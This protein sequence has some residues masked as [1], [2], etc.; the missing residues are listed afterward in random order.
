MR[1][2]CITA[3]LGSTLMLTGCPEPEPTPPPDEA[4]LAGDWTG[5]ASDGRV[6]TLT[7]DDVG[8][9]VEIETTGDGGATITVNVPD[10]TS[11]V[12]GDNVRVEVPVDNATA[13]YTGTLSDNQNRIDG[14]LSREVSVTDNVTVTIPQGPLDLIRVGADA[15]ED[16]TCDEGEECVDG[17]CVA[18]DSCEGVTCD[19]GEECVNGQCVAVDPC[20]GVTCDPGE[21]CVAGLCVPEEPGGG[22]AVAGE[23]IYT[24][25]CL[26][27]HGADATGGIGPNIQGARAAEITVATS[28]G[29]GHVVYDISAQDALD[30][31]AYL[32][33][34]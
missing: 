18:A 10:A 15:C 24:A 3:L 30:L 33:S 5:T 26:V 28:G 25:N 21:I 14:D 20:E 27:C 1:V 19:P 12:N 32:G 6:F 29:G 22:D 31:E 4:V 11:T 13:V 8:V 7:F 17:E 9:L 23:T 2:L 34:F 16:V